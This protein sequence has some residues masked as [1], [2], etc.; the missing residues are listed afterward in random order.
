MN[1]T[2]LFG[3]SYSS[4]RDL[5]FAT[6]DPSRE[7]AAG[8]YTLKQPCTVSNVYIFCDFFAHHVLF[9]CFF[10]FCHLSNCII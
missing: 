6:S 2:F 10:L 7:A 4:G 3:I 8:S 9:H 1:Y 5:A